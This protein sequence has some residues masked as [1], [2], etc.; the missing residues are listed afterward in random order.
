MEAT[1]LLVTGGAGFIGANLVRWLHGRHQSLRLTIV[2]KLTYAGHR[3]YLAGLLDDDRVDLVVADIAC[4]EA[5]DGLFDRHDFDGIIHLAAES[6]VDR[7]IQGPRAF[8]DTNVVGTFVLLEC[9]RSHFVD[10]QRPGRFLHVSTDEI[11]GSLGPRGRFNE[12]SPV[13]PSSPYSATKAASDHL[14]QAYHRTY[15]LDAVITNCSN[16]FGPYQHPEKL[17]PLAVRCLRDGDPIP[18]YGDGQNVRDWLF[19]DDHCRALETVFRRGRIGERYN[20]GAQNERTNLAL[21]HQICDHVDDLTGRPDGHSR[22]FLTFVNDRPGHDRRYAIDPTKI[23]DEL[24]WRAAHD[25]DDALART[26]AWYLEN[27]SALWGV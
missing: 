16:N 4:R 21:L 23:R 15:G 11:Y 9:A 12:A 7:S 3:R 19:V 8:V 24:D 13:D 17:I 14:V 25:F 5:M 26:V 27:L 6:H 10:R 18:V 22:Q 20:I 1:H 2:D